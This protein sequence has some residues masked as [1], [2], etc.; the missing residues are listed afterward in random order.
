MTCWRSA[1]YLN[2]IAPVHHSV[3]SDQL[4]FPFDIRAG[5]RLWDALYFNPRVFQPDSSKS[6]IWNRGAYLVTRARTLR[7]LPH[8]QEPARGR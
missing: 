6:G 2:T 8:S 1:S 4:P 7:G 3:H 5:M